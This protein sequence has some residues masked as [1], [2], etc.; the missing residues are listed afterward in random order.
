MSRITPFTPASGILTY[1]QPCGALQANSL[2]S[3][4]AAEMEDILVSS[5]PTVNAFLRD[6][7]LPFH[8]LYEGNK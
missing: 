8:P 1:H 4:H 3:I 7:L 6:I 2:S 5:S